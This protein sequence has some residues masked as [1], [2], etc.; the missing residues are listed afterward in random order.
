VLIDTPLLVV[1]E[2]PAPLLVAKLASG[3]GLSS[4]VAGHRILGGEY[5]AELDQQAVDIL[6]PHGLF[7]VLRP[8]LVNHDPVAIAPAAFE[9]VLKHHCVADMNTT[10]YDG[11]ELVD[12]DTE[13]GGVRGVLTDGRSRWDVRADAFVDTSALPSDLQGAVVAASRVAN[14]VVDDAVGRSGSPEGG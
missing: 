2:G 5:P 11:M 8:Y 6:T 13:G 14:Q 1:G 4:L 9:E 7:D 3:R 10:V 12:A